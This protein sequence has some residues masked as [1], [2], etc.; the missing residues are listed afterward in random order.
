MKKWIILGILA[1]L[2][3]FSFLYVEKNAEP[4]A[5]ANVP[6]K[7]TDTATF[8]EVPSIAVLSNLNELTDEERNSLN[9]LKTKYHSFFQQLENETHKKFQQIANAAYEEYERHDDVLEAIQAMTTYYHQLKS[10]E[11]QTDISFQKI[12]LE[13][14]R[15]LQDAGLPINEADVFKEEYEKKKHEQMQEFLNFTKDH[16]HD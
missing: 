5:V 2:V 11:E 6:T 15:E 13:L 16:H 12:Y 3:I 4:K 10:L 1:E 7:K 9:E 8:K 14:Q